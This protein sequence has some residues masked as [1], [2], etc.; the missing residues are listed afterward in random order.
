MAS[1][2]TFEVLLVEDNIPDI[3]LMK[4]LLSKVDVSIRLSIASDGSSAT[5]FL[6]GHGNFRQRPLPDLIL[7]DL[8]L[9]Q[10]S[11][12]EILKEIKADPELCNI[13]ILVVSTSL[14][15]VEINEVYRLGASAFLAKPGDLDLFEKT[16]HSIVDFWLKRATL[17]SPN[18]YYRG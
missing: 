16:V 1:P 17:P 4:L 7:L 8:N 6:L 5:D 14:N 13:P 2:R 11:G 12:R 15:K 3:E 18:L 10:K 9:P